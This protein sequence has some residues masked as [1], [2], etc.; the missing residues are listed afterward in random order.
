MARSGPLLSEAQW[1]KIA[2][3]LPRPPRN[4]YFSGKSCQRAPLR[5]IH[6]IPCNT[7]R[8]SIHGRPPQ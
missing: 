1:K 4:R 5:R 8:F 7:R 6:R 3:L 2:P